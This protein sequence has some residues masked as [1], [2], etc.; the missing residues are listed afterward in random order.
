MPAM[1]VWPVSGSVRTRKV[2]SSS[3]SFCSATRQL[4]LVGLGLGL[5]GDVDDRVR[6]LHRLEDDRL[7]LV[8]EGVAGPD[9]LEADRPPRC[10]RPALPRS[11]H[12]CWRA[13]AA[14]GRPARACP[15]CCCGRRLPASSD[16]GVDPE[17]GQPA[18]EGVGRDLEGQRRERLVV[19]GPALDVRLVVVRQVTLDR[20][21]VLGA[22]QVVHHGVE[23]RLDALVL[24]GRAAEHRHD[25]AADR[26]LPDRRLDLL[27][28]QLLAREV[29]LHQDV[30][31]LHRRLDQLVPGVLDRL[32]V[33]VGHRHLGE[34]LA[35]RRLVEDELDPAEDVDV[36]G[37]Q[38]RP[39]PTGSWSGKARGVSRSRIILR[40][41]S[42]SAPTRSIL[43]TK[44]S[45]GT[46]Y[47]SAWRQTVSVCGSTPP[48]ESSSATAP[49]S[50]RSD[51]STS[52]VKSTW[53]GVSMMLIRY[54]VPWRP[55]AGRRGRRDRDAALLLLLHPVHGRGAVVHFTDLVGLA[56]V[57]Q[58]ALGRSRL[59][60]IDVG[61][62][63]DVPIA[64]ER[65]RTC[66]A[67]PSSTQKR[68]D[69]APPRRGGLA[70][71]HVRAC[72]LARNPLGDS[73]A[74]CSEEPEVALGCPSSR[75]PMSTSVERRSRESSEI[76]RLTTTLTSD[77]AR[78]RGWPRPSG[79]CLP[80][81]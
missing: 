49:S 17:V 66:H 73:H 20:R 64:I 16:A 36:P 51:R 70:P 37:E 13:S 52:T 5:D 6:E 31:V 26:G 78:T 45:R 79:A 1:I 50:T 12:A 58:D 14:G 39:T 10:R 22:R 47:R 57:V 68:G 9:V 44:I 71:R 61:H 60:G 62:D 19:H 59:P 18:H 34:R 30:V 38:S 42:K 40:Q 8:A 77:S 32:L 21:D 76:S 33:G 81:S 15:W 46:P 24:E 63:A 80:S 7:V 56:G 55:E 41:R 75:A 29:L 35:Q 43:L 54:S 11:P 72:T 4:V 2:G 65:C 48:T 69:R 67:L 28:G 74:L 53:P 25:V 27:E 3:A 23:Q